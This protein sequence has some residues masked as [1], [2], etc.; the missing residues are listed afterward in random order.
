MDSLCHTPL[1]AALREAGLKQRTRPGNA[2]LMVSANIADID[3]ATT[4]GRRA[5]AVQSVEAL[6]AD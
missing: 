5:S 3:P 2:A 6:A 4:H 1:G